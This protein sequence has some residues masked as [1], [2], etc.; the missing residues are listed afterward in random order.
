MQKD[1]KSVMIREYIFLIGQ[2]EI[3]MEGTWAPT[4]LAV[5]LKDSGEKKI[6]P[7]L[8]EIHLSPML[9]EGTND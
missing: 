6:F 8:G 7:I 3:K 5:A 1:R 2:Q 9:N 4:Y